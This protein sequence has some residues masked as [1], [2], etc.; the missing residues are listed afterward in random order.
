M[1][2]VIIFITAGSRVSNL[3]LV[4]NL[5]MLGTWTV[6]RAS[7][8]SYNETLLQLWGR[9]RVVWLGDRQQSVTPK[10]KSSGPNK[11]PRPDPGCPQLETNPLLR[12][13]QNLLHHTHMLM[14]RGTSQVPMSM[15]M[16]C[17]P[18]MTDISTHI[19]MLTDASLLQS[20][21]LNRLLLSTN[22]M[23]HTSAMMRITR[24][25]S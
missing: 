24:M 11:F 5:N 16:H 12:C 4:R 1:R 19:I 13:T 9:C 21:L 6:N 23:L 18:E 20:P 10:K 3:A 25:R 8:K 7:G 22:T 15:L 2:G 14:P 17:R